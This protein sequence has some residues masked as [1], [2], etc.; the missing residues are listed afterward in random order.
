[1]SVFSRMMDKEHEKIA[2]LMKA[3]SFYSNVENWEHKAI[4]RKDDQGELDVQYP[5]S[6]I[7]KDQGAKARKAFEEINDLPLW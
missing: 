4:Y 1:M 2:I 5:A 7:D 6:E 3:L